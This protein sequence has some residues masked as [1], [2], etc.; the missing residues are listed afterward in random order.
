MRRI[1]FAQRKIICNFCTWL[2]KEVENILKLR[3]FQPKHC[4]V[5]EEL[6][7]AMNNVNKS[8]INE[9]QKELNES[10]NGGNKSQVKLTN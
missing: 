1:S 5:Y 4:V 2:S 3:Q 9:P 6:K 8:G 7:K 10:E